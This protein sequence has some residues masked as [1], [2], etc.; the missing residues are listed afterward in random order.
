M[1]TIHTFSKPTT[2]R[3][4]FLVNCSLVLVTITSLQF[5]ENYAKREAK[6]ADGQE[7]ACDFCDGWPTFETEEEFSRHYVEN[8]LRQKMDEQMAYFL[9]DFNGVVAIRQMLGINLEGK[10]AE[11][12]NAHVPRPELAM[13]RPRRQSQSRRL[14]NL[15]NLSVIKKHALFI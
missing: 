6:K 2:G 13:E 3:Y 12:D 14:D 9:T 8:H 15:T 11:A 7:L 10:K 1:T 5:G 4:V